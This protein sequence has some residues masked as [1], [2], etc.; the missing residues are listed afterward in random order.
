MLQNGHRNV[1]TRKD[2]DSN[3]KMWQK[4]GFEMKETFI[5]DEK[6]YRQKVPFLMCW[7]RLFK[8]YNFTCANVRQ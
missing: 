5:R 1:L 6:K 4:A 8:Y 3:I 2:L 7:N